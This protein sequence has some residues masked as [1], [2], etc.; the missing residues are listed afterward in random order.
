MQSSLEDLATSHVNQLLM[1]FEK[2]REFC[3]E[4]VQFSETVMFG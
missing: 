3:D 4:I 1:C 2:I